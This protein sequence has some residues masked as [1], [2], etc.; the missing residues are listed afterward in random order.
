MRDRTPKMLD[1][2][3]L[4]SQAQSERKRPESFRM[5]SELVNVA[6]RREQVKYLF[7]ILEFSQ[8]PFAN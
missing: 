3:G 7:V 6:A 1:F 8:I 5:S 4:A 2:L